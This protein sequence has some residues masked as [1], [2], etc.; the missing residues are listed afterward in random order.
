MATNNLLTLLNSSYDSFSNLY[1]IALTTAPDG[2]TAPLLTSGSDIRVM[3]FKV[4]SLRLGEYE[5]HYKTVS[6]PR[7]NAQITGEREFEL[8]FRIDANWDLYKEL[9][10]WKDLFIKLSTDE[11]NFGIYNNVTGTLGNYAKVTVTALKSTTEAL[12]SDGDSTTTNPIEWVFD[13]VLLYDLV[14][15][16]FNRESSVP[17]EITAKFLF[18]EFIPPTYAGVQTFTGAV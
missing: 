16:V 11:I 5:N 9:K 3:N 6:L 1:S 7:F 17:V 4:P 13:H 14:E 12:S 15:P 10:A 2:L 8:R 18:G